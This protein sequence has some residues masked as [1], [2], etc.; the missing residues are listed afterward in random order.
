MEM[1]IVW[2]RITDEGSVPKMR[3]WSI[4]LIKYDLKWCLHLSR[5]LLFNYEGLF[6]D[7]GIL[8]NNMKSPSP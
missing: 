2:L 4:S 8:L 5:S 1:P 7:T 3:I 6:V